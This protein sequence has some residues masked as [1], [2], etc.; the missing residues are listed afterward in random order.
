MRKRDLRH[1][2][3]ETESPVLV[4]AITRICK[5]NTFTQIYERLAGATAMVGILGSSSTTFRA[6]WAIPVLA[7]YPLSILAVWGF[8]KLF[9]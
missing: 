2:K 3:D 6:V 4:N 5:V 9:T 7:I 8:D 1:V